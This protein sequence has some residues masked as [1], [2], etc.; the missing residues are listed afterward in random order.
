MADLNALA[1]RLNKIADNIEAAPS[2]V[3]AAFTLVLVEELI[4]RTPVDTSKALSNWLTSLDDPVLIDQDAY[5]EGLRGSTASASKAEALAFAAR[6]L[7]N[8]EPGQDIFLA[9]SAPYIRDLENGSS[10]QAP[11]GFTKQ[12]LAIARA[13]LPTIIKEVLKNGR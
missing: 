7:A 10:S 1:K 8:K 4:E 11:A 5:Y 2:K 9:N 12:S 3:A 6:I 13:K